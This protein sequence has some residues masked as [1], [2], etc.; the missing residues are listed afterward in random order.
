MLGTVGGEAMDNQINGLQTL[1]VGVED[2]GKPLPGP[3]RIEG[4]R[5]LGCGRD[6]GRAIYGGALAGRRLQHPGGRN[7][8]SSIE[9][10]A[11]ALSNKDS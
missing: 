9:V 6:R 2:E 10:F 4:V 3:S 11:L 8:T 7:A 5:R 1:K